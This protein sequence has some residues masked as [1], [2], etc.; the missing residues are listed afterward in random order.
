MLEY[1]QRRW[2]PFLIGHEWRNT[3]FG[4]SAKYFGDSEIQ[5][6]GDQTVPNMLA[7]DCCSTCPGPRWVPVIVQQLSSYYLRV[8]SVLFIFWVCFF[9][10]IRFLMICGIS[11]YLYLL[12]TDLKFCSKVDGTGSSIWW[13]WLILPLLPLCL[14]C[15]QIDVMSFFPERVQAVGYCWVRASLHSSWYA[16]GRTLTW[17]SLLSPDLNLIRR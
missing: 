2:R 17:D 7:I 15:D 9:P 5:V 12:V 8:R 14:S 13:R 10:W 11:P 6:S 4:C 1:L 16:P 3:F